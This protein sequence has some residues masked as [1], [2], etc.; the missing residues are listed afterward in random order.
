MKVCIGAS[1][2]ASRVSQ[3]LARR[4]CSTCCADI[5]GAFRGR[6]IADAVHHQHATGV[7]A[8]RFDQGAIA[9]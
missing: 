8:A 5:P 4:G 9:G 1:E 7:A 2:I 6:Q 3:M